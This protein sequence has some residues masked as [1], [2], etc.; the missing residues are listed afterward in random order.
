[1]CVWQSTRHEL[2][3]GIERSRIRMAT[4]QLGTRADLEHAPIAEH[5]RA[6]RNAQQALARSIDGD[7]FRGVVQQ[8]VGGASR[9]RARRGVAARRGGHAAAAGARFTR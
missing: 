9:H 4:G 5:H 3:A 1:M 7:D 8:H 2:A 6:A